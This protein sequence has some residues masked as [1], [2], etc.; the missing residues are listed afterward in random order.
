MAPSPHS[1]PSVR[2]LVVG[3]PGCGKSTLCALLANSGD[4][5]DV[6]VPPR[7]QGADVHVR[8]VHTFGGGGAQAQVACVELWDVSGN[9]EAYGLLLPLVLG[10]QAGAVAALVLCYDLS[11]PRHGLASLSRWAALCGAHAT[12]ACPPAAHPATPLAGRLR[13]MGVAAPV[14]VVGLKSD[15]AVPAHS[16]RPTLGLLASL[17]L[18]PLH[19]A[20][21]LLRGWTTRMRG[22]MPLAAR[23][24]GLLPEFATREQRDAALFNEATVCC[25]PGYGR[26]DTEALDAFFRHAIGQSVLTGGDGALLPGIHR[27]RR[28]WSGASNSSFEF[29]LSPSAQGQSTPVALRPAAAAAAARGFSMLRTSSFSNLSMDAML[30]PEAALDDVDGGRLT[31]ADSDKS[32]PLQTRS[33]AW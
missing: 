30:D 21:S 3:D 6:E 24:E 5:D 14:L 19:R 31:W 22:R 12:W 2:V 17:L 10:P 13:E 32:P 23:E 9:Q 29:G 28:S 1:V 15:A 25:A 26:V 8:L 4:G 11:S 27:H 16:A 20:A 18:L 33:R 7:T